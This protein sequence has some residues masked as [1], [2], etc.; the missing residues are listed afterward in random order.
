VIVGV[1]NVEIHRLTDLFTA[2]DGHKVGEEVDVHVVHS[3]RRRTVKVSL[4]A[5]PN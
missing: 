5:L 4:Q 1:G 2:L 3:G